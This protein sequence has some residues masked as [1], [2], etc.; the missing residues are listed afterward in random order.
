MV[1][2]ANL[3]GLERKEGSTLNVV[4]IVLLGVSMLMFAAAAANAVSGE[5]LRP[6]L[7]PG[8]P[9][10][11]AGVLLVSLFRISDTVRPVNGL[12]M[13]GAVWFVAIFFGTT[14]YLLSGFSFPDAV[15]ESTS[16]FTTCGA[17]VWDGSAELSAGIL[18]WRSLTQWIGG[19]AIILIFLFI[20]PLIGF[21]GRTM[22]GNEIHGSGSPNFT[23]RMKDAGKQFVV[24]YAGLTT[25]M[26]AIMLALG[27]DAMDSLCITLSTVSTGGFLNS[28]GS[29]QGCRMVVKWVVVVFMF[30]GGTNFY[31][32][33]KAVTAKDPR[34][35]FK[36]TEFRTMF[37]WFGFLVCFILYL[38]YDAGVDPSG[39]G[40]FVENFTD[41]S[42]NV[43]SMATS[44]GY[45]SSDYTTWTH[46]AVV[47]LFVA[48]FV[49]SSAGSTGG[50]VKI[51]R[52]I[53]VATYVRNG[54]RKLVHPHGVFD[55]KYSGS[56]LDEGTVNAT[57][58]I[59]I[60]F[61]V[62]AVVGTMVVMLHG[63]PINEAITT[64]VACLADTGPATGSF[65]PLS[66]YGGAPASLKFF[67]SLLMWVG[68]LE[69]MAAIALLTPGFWKELITRGR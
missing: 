8:A 38:L 3:F 30:L 14:P 4:G 24:I 15:F 17:T 45:G 42:F 54:L 49:G 40:S 47:L 25:V 19:I 43:V 44:T 61:M 5:S 46:G 2:L 7:V 64:T 33:Y 29:M 63:I 67:Y 6:F 28:G 57:V 31:L 39:K 35:Y 66:G 56:S 62:T 11:V 21:G 23:A 51:S 13:L 1:G 41:V 36:N 27:N 59:F 65:G 18:L 37:L 52:I 69:V 60:M 55:V 53:I 22:F 16:G 50:G 32:H 48:V 20:M 26:L 58:T 68:R 10:F 9:G 34:T 12:F